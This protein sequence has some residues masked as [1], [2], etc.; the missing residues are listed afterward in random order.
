MHYI[1][2]AY[3]RGCIMLSD[4]DFHDS[5]DRPDYTGEASQKLRE[6]GVIVGLT[7]TRHVVHKRGCW[8]PRFVTMNY[9]PCEHRLQDFYNSGRNIINTQ[10]IMATSIQ[11]YATLPLGERHFSKIF[12]KF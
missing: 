4:I 12:Q 9:F 1:F 6:A 7:A 3:G 5:S 10:F 2:P 8:D 11:S